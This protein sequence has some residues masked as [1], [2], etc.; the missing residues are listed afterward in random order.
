MADQRFLG[1]E[2]SAVEKRTARA[3]LECKDESRLPEVWFVS[4]REVQRRMIKDNSELLD[5]LQESHDLRLRLAR[6]VL[7]SP[8]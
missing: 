6:K 1:D 4:E 8:S 3:D 5:E 2:V 7:S